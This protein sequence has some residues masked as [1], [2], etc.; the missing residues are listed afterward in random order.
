MVADRGLRWPRRTQ[1]NLLNIVT[2]L[3]RSTYW[4]PLSWSFIKYYEASWSLTCADFT[5][6]ISDCAWL[7]S[8]SISAVKIQASKH[9][10]HD[11]P[12]YLDVLLSSL[13]SI[14][15][16]ASPI[17]TRPRSTMNR[18]MTSLATTVPASL[19]WGTLVGLGKLQPVDKQ[20]SGQRACPLNKGLA[21]SDLSRNSLW[22]FLKEGC[23]KSSILVL[24]PM[25]SGYHHFRK[26]P[27]S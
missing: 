16:A 14:W 24:K 21:H 11:A 15:S 7:L 5:T 1:C 20:F 26:P 27:H 22:S 19:D 3:S 2:P 4:E 25:V 18:S 6:T 10:K 12:R 17:F 23:P 8:V 13:A 9:L